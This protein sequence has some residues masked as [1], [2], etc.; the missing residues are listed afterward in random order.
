[1]SAVASDVGRGRM[2][3]AGGVCCR[4]GKSDVGWGRLMLAEGV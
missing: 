3:S 1:M 4:L 2:M